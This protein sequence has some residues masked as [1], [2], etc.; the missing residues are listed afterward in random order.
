MSLAQLIEHLPAI[1]T[2]A[3]KSNLGVLSLAI[4]ALA[5]LAVIFGG[6]LSPNAKMAFLVLSLFALCL[7]GWKTI[8]IGS[9]GF[10][11]VVNA[12]YGFEERSCSATTKVIKYVADHCAAF[13]ARCYVPVTNEDLC[14]DPAKGVTKTLTAKI[15]CGDD[16]KTRSAKETDKSLTLSC[17]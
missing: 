13:R 12:E 16:E 8:E 15:M 3:S 5:V 7:F 17:P 9:G 11:Q 4:M 2:A 14:G 6:Q 10:M 1:I